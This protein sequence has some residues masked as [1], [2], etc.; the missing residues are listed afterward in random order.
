MEPHGQKLTD[1]A[2]PGRPRQ[3][4][5]RGARRRPRTPRTQCP[6]RALAQPS[7]P[8]HQLHGNPTHLP[9]QCPRRPKQ[10]RTISTTTRTARPLHATGSGNT[11]KYRPKNLGQLA[12][13]S[14]RAYPQRPLHRTGKKRPRPRQSVCVAGSAAGVRVMRVLRVPA[15]RIPK[16]VTPPL[17]FL[18][19]RMGSTL[20]TLITLIRLS[21]VYCCSGGGSFFNI[22]CRSPEMLA[23][24]K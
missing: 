13:L 17:P 15:S 16:Y 3:K 18:S 7:Q 14:S 8:Q 21:T 23:W 4:H 1:L 6:H 9:R 11:R 20:K 22:S 19:R 10:R 2:R 12:R 5:G 24:P